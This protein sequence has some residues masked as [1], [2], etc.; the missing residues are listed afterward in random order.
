MQRKCL[1]EFEQGDRQLVTGGIYRVVTIEGLS[2]SEYDIQLSQNPQMD[3]G[4]VISRAVLPRYL[5]MEIDCQQEQRD[6]FV[7][8]FNPRHTGKLTILWN[9]VRRWINYEVQNNKVKPGTVWE[10]PSFT[11]QLVCPDPFFNDMN[12]YGRN[13]AEIQPLIAFPF[14]WL[15][16]RGYVSDYVMLGKEAALNN[17]GDI[18]TGLIVEILARGAVKNPRLE[19]GTEDYI[20]VDVV[21]STGDTLRINT[22]KGRKQVLLNGEDVLHRIDRK[23]TWLTLPVGLSTLSYSA[24]YGSNDMDVMVYFTPQ[25]LGI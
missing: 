6:Q 25:Y 3:G 1:L 7:R 20:A 15:T 18:E 13:I 24:E 2:S 5:V 11:L 12:D 14:V 8:F 19:L 21:M 9:G 22:N 10:K 17:S 23:S 4:R 16:G